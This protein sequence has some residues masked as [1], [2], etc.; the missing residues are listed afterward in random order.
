MSVIALGKE[1]W[2]LL[3]L[4]HVYKHENNSKWK[5]LSSFT[6]WPP[7]VKPAKHE[8]YFR[9]TILFT[10]R[11]SFQI[12]LCKSKRIPGKPAASVCSRSSYFQKY[13]FLEEK[14]FRNARKAQ[15]NQ[16]TLYTA[17]NAAIWVAG[18]SVE[19]E[20]QERMNLFKCNAKKCKNYWTGIWI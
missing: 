7:T 13:F 5:T 17:R 1:N 4:A 16:D 20:D 10:G 12:F 18:L 19:S 14:S 15:G 11:R 6:P 9:R 8:W 3:K 2:Y